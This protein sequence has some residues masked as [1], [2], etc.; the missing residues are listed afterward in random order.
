MFEITFVLQSSIAKT[1]GVFKGLR[2]SLSDSVIQFNQY[3]IFVKTHSFSN[4]IFY[5]TAQHDRLYTLNLDKISS[6]HK[7]RGAC[8]Y[9]HC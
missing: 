8:L 2:H 6:D 5:Y 1:K 3:S 9:S 4:F 7:K